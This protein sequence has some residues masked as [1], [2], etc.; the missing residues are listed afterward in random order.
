MTAIED[1]SVLK[2]A[3]TPGLLSP[4]PRSKDRPHRLRRALAHV[5][6]VV[7]PLLFVLVVWELWVELKHLPPAVA[8]EKDSEFPQG[9]ATL[10]ARAQM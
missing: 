2:E 8:P 4:L 6:H 9:R 1:L 7:W 3:D 5:V 10:T